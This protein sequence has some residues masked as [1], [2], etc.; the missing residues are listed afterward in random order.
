MI[1]ENVVAVGRHGA[2]PDARTDQ[3]ARSAKLGYVPRQRNVFYELIDEIASQ[4]G[5]EANHARSQI[6]ARRAASWNRLCRFIVPGDSTRMQTCLDISLSRCS[7]IAKLVRFRLRVDLCGRRMTSRT[8]DSCRSDLTKAYSDLRRG[9]V[10]RSGRRQLR[11][12]GPAR[13]IGLLG[14]NGAGKT[15]ALRILSTVLQPTGGTRHRRR[16]RRAS[17]SPR[18]SAIRSASCRPTRRLRPHDRLGDGRV[19]RPAVRH[20][21]RARCASG[22]RRCSTRLQM[23]EIRDVLG[24]KMSHRHEAEGLDRPGDRPRS[25]GADLRRSRRPASTCSSPGRC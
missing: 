23:N 18:W 13:S 4:R 11:R 2:L 25:A 14:P 22:W 10:S 12:A 17:R 16:L 7:R 6:G 24:A 20:G 9:E 1:E 5:I 3:A 19:L 21:R 8:S 15:T